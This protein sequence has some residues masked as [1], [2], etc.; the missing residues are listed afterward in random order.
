VKQPTS[1]ASLADWM[2]RRVKRMD[3]IDMGCVKAGAMLF[4]LLAAKL[5]PPLLAADPWV[6]AVALVIVSIRSVVRL[7]SGEAV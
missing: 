1:F 4:A 5:W 6:Y 2:D 7:L 3:W